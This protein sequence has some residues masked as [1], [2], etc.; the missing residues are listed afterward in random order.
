MKRYSTN[1]HRRLFE[2]KVGE[3]MH[4]EYDDVVYVKMSD[5][6]EDLNK[7]GAL[8]AAGVDNWEGYNDAMFG[9]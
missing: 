2:L 3:L 7:L 4:P 9:E 6:R 1:A 8:E 5:V